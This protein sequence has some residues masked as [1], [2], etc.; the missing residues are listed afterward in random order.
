MKITKQMLMS[1]IKEELE[2]VME[3]YGYQSAGMPSM[4]G[5]EELEEGEYDEIMGEADTMIPPARTSAYKLKQGIKQGV[6][7]RLGSLAAAGALAGGV[8]TGAGLSHSMAQEPREVVASA[9]Y[10]TQGRINAIAK[11]FV[12]LPYRMQGGRTGTVTI[13]QALEAAEQASKFASRKDRSEYMHNT[14]N[15]VDEYGQDIPDYM[16]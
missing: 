13:E 2:L 5:E 8:A 6:K 12:G 7:Q 3:G 15:I 16:K 1:I 9:D 14:L 10:M 11:Q 4:G